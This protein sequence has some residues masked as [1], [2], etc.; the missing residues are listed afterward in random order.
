LAIASYL[1]LVQGGV[2]PIDNWPT[3]AVVSFATGLVTTEIIGRLEG[4]A[5]SSIAPDAQ[6]VSPAQ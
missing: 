6:Q 4:F 3:I 1:I 2:N 5:R